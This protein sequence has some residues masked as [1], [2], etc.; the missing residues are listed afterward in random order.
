MI[1]NAYKTAHIVILQ[2][3]AIDIIIDI[4]KIG[5]NLIQQGYYNWKLEKEKAYLAKKK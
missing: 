4:W 5:P 1:K 2:E 3:N